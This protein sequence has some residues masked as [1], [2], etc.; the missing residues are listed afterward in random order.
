[1]LPWVYSFFALKC[2]GYPPEHTAVKKGIEGLE[3]FIV[4]DEDNFLLE[5]AT[6]LVWDTA[7]TVLAL[8]D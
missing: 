5:P 8:H 4:E 7:W 2:L 1:M 6:S 3:G